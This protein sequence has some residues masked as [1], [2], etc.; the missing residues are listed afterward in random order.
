[1]T[2]LQHNLHGYDKIGEV[3]SLGSFESFLCY[4]EGPVK[5]GV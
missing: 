5:C 3:K 2:Y 1:M 4:F